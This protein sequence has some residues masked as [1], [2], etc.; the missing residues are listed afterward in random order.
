MQE[1][2]PGT[3]WKNLF[4]ER[5]PA[6]HKWLQSTS[7]FVDSKTALAALMQYMPEMRP[8]HDR[9]CSLVEAEDMASAFLT[10]FQPPAYFSACSQVVSTLDEVQLVR[11]YDY[12][13]DRFEANLLMTAWNGKKVIA[14]SDCLVGVLDGMNNDG[15]A[16]SLTFGGRK[17]LGFGFGIPFI[18]RY[19]LEF[20]STVD[21]AVEVLLRVPSHMA[22]NVTIT[23]KT[24]QVKTVQ[25]APDK[26]AHVSDRAFATNHQEAIE[27]KENADFNRTMERAIHIE[28]LLRTEQTGEELTREFLKAP[29]YNTRYSEGLGT[30]YTAVYRPQKGEVQLHWQNDQ[31]TQSFDSFTEEQKFISFQFPEQSPKSIRAIK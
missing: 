8:T 2:Q 13:A 20:C 22:Y 1:L 21:E 18:L 6:Y 28:G 30:L 19:I 16:L 25:L 9:L 26:S 31:M 3:K 15:L 4:R 10:G 17:T 12:H 24:G 23:D 14:S 27:W 29:L 5:W 11:N 7:P